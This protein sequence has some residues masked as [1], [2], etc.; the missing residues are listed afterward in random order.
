VKSRLEAEAHRKCAEGLSVYLEK[1]HRKQIAA[2][3][4]T[5]LISGVVCAA[6]LYTYNRVTDSDVVDNILYFIPIVL[7]TVTSTGYSI[8]TVDDNDAKD[9]EDFN[10]VCDELKADEEEDEEDEVDDQD[11]D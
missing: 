7:A 9:A 3:F 4:T 1:Q 8:I 2:G 6:G 11:S 10:A 5:G